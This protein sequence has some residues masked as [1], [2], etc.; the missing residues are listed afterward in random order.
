MNKC[1]KHTQPLV[2][3][4]KIFSNMATDFN[5]GDK[6]KFQ[7]SS[8]SDTYSSFG[9]IINNVLPNIY[10]IA[11]LIIFFMI[12]AGGFIMITNA[13]NSDKQQD[14]KKIITTAIIGFIVIFA[15]YWIIQIIQIVT[16]IPILDS[17]L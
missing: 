12:I 11:G 3:Y 7:G 4:V 8:A 5:I 17:G 2:D 16:G 9:D 15:S 6:L 10:I 14:G 1:S 13:G